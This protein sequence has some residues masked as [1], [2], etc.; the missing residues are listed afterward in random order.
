V[1]MNIEKLAALPTC[2]A[3]T[4]MKSSNPQCCLASRKL[5]SIWKTQLVIGYQQVIIQVQII[6]EQQYFCG[7]AINQVGF[8]YHSLTNCMVKKAGHPLKREYYRH[9]PHKHHAFWTA[10]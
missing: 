3:P 8:S 9:T 1:T 10:Q 4:F 6:T 7:L 2:V 5:N